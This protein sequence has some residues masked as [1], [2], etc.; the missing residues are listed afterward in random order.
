MKRILEVRVYKPGGL[1]PE[2][3]TFSDVNMRRA[4]RTARPGD[5]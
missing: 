5:T 1:T 2:V 4:S 3:A